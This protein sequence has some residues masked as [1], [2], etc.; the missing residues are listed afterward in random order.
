TGGYGR[1]GMGVG[2]GPAGDAGVNLA[3]RGANDAYWQIRYE[4]NDRVIVGYKST[5]DPV[6]D[7]TLQTVLFRALTPPEP[8]CE[9][10]GI[11]HQGGTLNW[12]RGDY[13]VVASSLDDPWFDGTGLDASSVLQGLVGP[14]TDTI[15][16][17]MSAEDS[18]GNQLPVFC[19]REM[20]GD[21]LGN[22]DTVAYTAPSGAVVFAAGSN[23]FVW[24][25]ADGSSLSRVGAGLVDPRLQ[26]FVA[27]ML[28]DLSASR[29]ADLTLALSP[30]SSADSSGEVR[31]VALVGN[32]GPDAVRR[33]TLAF[34]L[35]HGVGL[36][37]VEST[38]MR[39]TLAPLDCELG[40]LDAG[41]SVTAVFT[42]HASAGHPCAIRARVAAAT[43][44][45]PNPTSAE[46]RLVIPIG[47]LRPG[48]TRRSARAI[49]RHA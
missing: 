38:G 7:P 20:G 1:A 37:R 5:A 47:H 25:L 9:L 18:C 41:A 17:N 29:T 36:V 46:A 34:E 13:A 44:R 19:H 40:Q 11:Q 35:P 23:Q 12:S 2:L 15:P 33:A 6:I 39:C 22:A 45:D 27:N 3:F 31:I 49:P 26:R 28:D 32:T 21:P 14:E 16:N 8:E 10:I 24:G 48:H 42:L 30:A 43:A 4:N